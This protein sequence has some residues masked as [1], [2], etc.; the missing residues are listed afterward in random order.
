MLR[1]FKSF[2][3]N[4][5]DN[6]NP[7][8]VPGDLAPTS[9][10][11]IRSEELV[12]TGF[13]KDIRP[14]SAQLDAVSIYFTDA[15]TDKISYKSSVEQ[16]MRAK[17]D[18]NNPKW[19]TQFLF[20]LRKKLEDNSSMYSNFKSFNIDNCRINDVVEESAKEVN[21]PTRLFPTKAYICMQGNEGVM[22]TDPHTGKR[23]IKQTEDDFIMRICNEN[24]VIKEAIAS[25]TVFFNHHQESDESNTFKF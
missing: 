3:K 23:G 13:E 25:S 7:S 17:L 22:Y 12:D 19:Q 15:L 21:I 2:L 4:P 5:Y 9:F 6:T 14:T 16:S 18:E 8:P 10:V 24:D 20:T 1:F 11:P